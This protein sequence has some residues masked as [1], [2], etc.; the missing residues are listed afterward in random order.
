MIRFSLSLS[1][2]FLL[3]F[4]GTVNIILLF[5]NILG[6]LIS[7]RLDKLLLPFSERFF[8]Y[9][10]HFSFSFSELNSLLSFSAF[11]FSLFFSSITSF[12]SLRL[13]SDSALISFFSDSLISSTW[14]ISSTI[15]SFSF[16]TDS[17]WF[18]LSSVF[19]ISWV[20]KSIFFFLCFGGNYNFIVF[21]FTYFH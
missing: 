17:L 6:S 18:E 12:L 11:S 5:W 2:S 1:I 4:E 7:K 9:W 14:G 8:E 15:V 13:D 3:L 21:G 10:I 19:S 20:F 16:F